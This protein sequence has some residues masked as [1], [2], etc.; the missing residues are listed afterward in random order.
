[1]VSS[2][3]CRPIMLPMFIL[4][5]FLVVFQCS[6]MFNNVHKDRPGQGVQA[7]PGRGGRACRAGWGRWSRTGTSGRVGYR[8]FV[9]PLVQPLAST[10]PKTIKWCADTWSQSDINHMIHINDINDIITSLVSVN[11][12]RSWTLLLHFLPKQCSH[13]GVL[14]DFQEPEGGGRG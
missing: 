6:I 7:E 9:C 8:V 11:V 3:L 2:M 13:W 10:C 4:Q 12:I 14:T 5:V 1:M